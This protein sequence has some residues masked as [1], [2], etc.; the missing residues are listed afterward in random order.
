MKQAGCPELDGPSSRVFGA[1]ALL[2]A[3]LTVL[4]GTFI[5]LNLLFPRSSV[6]PF[7]RT[8]AG[9]A[10]S[11]LVWGVIAIVVVR[12][13]FLPASIPVS[14]VELEHKESRKRDRAIPLVGLAGIAA[15]YW[16]ALLPGVL[17]GGDWNTWPYQPAADR[18][19][20]FPPIWTWNNF[21]KA[22]ILGAS[23]YPVE[24]IAGL[25]GHLG[26]SY[27]VAERLLFVGPILG[28]AFVGTLLLSEL[29]GSSR[30]LAT[31]AGFAVATSIPFIVFVVGGWFSLLAGAASM[32]LIIVL[33]NRA[34]SVNAT[35]REPVALGL[36]VGVVGWYDPRNIILL[37]LPLLVTAVSRLQQAVRMR[38]LGRLFVHSAIAAV[39]ALALQAHWLILIAT[40][41]RPS[42]PVGYQSSSQAVTFSFNSLA[43]SLMSFNYAWPILRLGQAQAIPWLWAG[44]PVLVALGVVRSKGHRVV[45]V[46]AV[47]YLGYAMLAAGA[48]PVFGSLYLWLFTHIPG[49]SLYRDSS[50]YLVP[51]GICAIIVA[52]S[53]SQRTR[54]DARD[55]ARRL[56]PEGR[57]RHGRWRQGSYVGVGCYLLAV[58]IGGSLPAWTGAWTGS[59]QAAQVPA[60]YAS[61]QRFLLLHGQGSILWIPGTSRFAPRGMPGYPS[62]SLS[63][64]ASNS[65]LSLGAADIDPATAW[66]SD[67]AVLDRVAV[68]DHVRYL[69]VLSRRSAFSGFGRQAAAVE[70][71]AR[72]LQRNV[73]C[74]YQCRKYTDFTVGILEPSVEGVL[75]AT[76]KWTSL[77]ELSRRTVNVGSWHLSR[78]SPQCLSRHPPWSAIL[79]GDN[80]AHLSALRSGLS[81]GVTEHGTH[82]ALA[83]RSGAAAITVPLTLR[84]ASKANRLSVY[85]VTA[86][87]QVGSG[88][89]VRLTVFA[90][91]DVSNCYVAGRG[92]KVTCVIGFLSG[93]EV[94]PSLEVSVFPFQ[95]TTRAIGPEVHAVLSDLEIRAGQIVVGAPL[96]GEVQEVEVGRTSSVLAGLAE[97]HHTQIMLPPSARREMVVLWQSYNAGWLTSTP[98]GRVV[99]GEHVEVNGWANGFVVPP[100]RAPETL[101]FRFAGQRWYDLGESLTWGALAVVVGVLLLSRGRRGWV[102]PRASRLGARRRGTSE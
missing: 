89:Y 2:V 80:F 11:A 52:V 17:A 78:P 68:A 79:N 44:L 25:L 18:L 24:A 3:A 99:D 69:V 12:S 36:V 32:P 49:I 35:W 62:I 16:R 53:G 10:I 101:V 42:L 64:L 43:D 94:T 28:V 98:S 83:I 70:A 95:E 63:D 5:I 33:T 26:I 55:F 100:H 71:Q 48:Q 74:R 61:L 91:S 30:Q 8:P 57:R 81:G 60:D 23:L 21:G 34:L 92:G 19:F 9:V 77:Q 59:L 45:G 73:V 82:L 93:A 66:L 39:V 27:G 87:M 84:C 22:N 51:G 7:D 47:C 102:R 37:A 29:C 54:G 90:G 41:F 56:R 88:A 97:F 20:P 6:R 67:T 15:T 14:D 13:H 58:S 1:F 86:H 75:T 40:G 46:M 31:L 96:T 38:F 85:V 4:S 72:L 65:T 76:E 50:V